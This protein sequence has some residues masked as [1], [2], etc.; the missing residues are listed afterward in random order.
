M[1]DG[2]ELISRIAAYKNNN[3]AEAKKAFELFC[4]YYER[5]VLQIAEVLCS[6]WGK[7]EG[8]A[9][10]IVQCAFDK[11]WL[12]PTFDISK[13][14]FTDIDRAILNWLSRILAHELSLFSRKGNCSH[15][16]QEDLP[17]ITSSSEFIENIFKD[18]YISGEK[19]DAIK[20][21]IDDAISGLNE[22]ERT[23]FLTYKLYL[24]TG[25][26]VPRI[27]LKKLRTKY[28]ISQGGIRQ[29][30]HRVSQKIKEL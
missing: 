17:L 14:K 24:M 4:G 10:D 12:Y 28:N 18:K 19:F 3:E 26:T 6:K 27:V 7:P 22:Q 29:C 11:V 20:L 2:A 16:T 1:I 25:H 9:H 5:R 30:H 8:Y 15:P 23:I 13:S 21:K